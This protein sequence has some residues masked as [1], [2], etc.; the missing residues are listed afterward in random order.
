MSTI[1][2]FNSTRK[3]SVNLTHELHQDGVVLSTVSI[4]MEDADGKWI[5][6]AMAARYARQGEPKMVVEFNE[7]EI[8]HV[9]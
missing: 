8:V 9:P 6:T 3:V 5:G 2:S 1:V 7:K 4:L